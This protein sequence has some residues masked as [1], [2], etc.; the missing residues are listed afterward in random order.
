MHKLFLAAIFGLLC[1]SAQAATVLSV[2]GD[3]L[4]GEGMS[5][6]GIFPN[7][8]VGLNFDVTEALTNA[9]FSLSFECFTPS[10]CSGV[11]QWTNTGL[12]PASSNQDAVAFSTGF[13][14]SM[15]TVFSGLD[16]AATTWSVLVSLDPRFDQTGN[17]TGSQSTPTTTSDGRASV[18]GTE[19][20]DSFNSPNPVRSTFAMSSASLDFELTAD[21]VSV[22]AVPLPASVWP[23]GAGLLALGWMRR[24]RSTAKK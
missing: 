17:W 23:F 14:Q 10:G 5:T 20:I 12:G 24:R 11:V 9:T 13:G 1:G 18:S 8:G 21:P 7:E 6:E 2:F 3:D 19:I 22:S 16:L 15:I 4:R